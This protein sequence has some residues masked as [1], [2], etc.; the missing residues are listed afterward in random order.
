[1]QPAEASKAEAGGGAAGG[2]AAAAAAVPSV[3]L[4]KAST[5]QP[6]QAATTEEQIVAKAEEIQVRQRRCWMKGYHPRQWRLHVHA[7]TPSTPAQH[8]YIYVYKVYI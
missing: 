7:S 6:D 8:T 5:S 2:A 3:R 4:S 1:M